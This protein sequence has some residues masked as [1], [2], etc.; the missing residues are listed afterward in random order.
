MQVDKAVWSCDGNSLE[1]VE[2]DVSAWGNLNVIGTKML[3][4]IELEA[5]SNKLLDAPTPYKQGITLTKWSDGNLEA[6]WNDEL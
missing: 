2:V 6:F 1:A 5:I 3:N 4:P